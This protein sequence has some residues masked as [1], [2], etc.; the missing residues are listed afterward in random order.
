MKNLFFKGKD[1]CLGLVAIIMIALS[2]LVYLNTSMNI[3]LSPLFFSTVL[4][5]VSWSLIVLLSFSIKE[6]LK[7]KRTM[8]LISEMEEKLV[9]LE[10][11]K[12]S[13]SSLSEVLYYSLKRA[14][15]GDFEHRTLT[16]GFSEEERKVLLTFNAFMDHLE[17]FLR[18]TSA[19]IS[20]ASEGK[21][22]KRVNKKG[23][24]S[25]YYSVID[26]INHSVDKMKD[27]YYLSFENEYKVSLL[28]ENK[29]DEEIQ[30]VQETLSSNFND[31]KEMLD[32]I[33]L[34]VTSA[35]KSKETLVETSESTQELVLLVRDNKD[36]SEGLITNAD[37]MSEIVSIIKDISEQTNLL[38]LNAAIEAARAG[39]HGRGFA[40]V[41]DEVRKLAEKT[42]T[43]MYEIEDKISL[44][45]SETER[46]EENSEKM[47][48]TSNTTEET[49]SLL[50]STLETLIVEMSSVNSS[51]SMIENKTFV[52]LSMLDHI[53]YKNAVFRALNLKESTSLPNSTNCRFG[54]WYN[55]K[56]K[57]IFGRESIFQDI[58][59]YH[60]DVHK[61][62][63]YLTSE[64][65]LSNSSDKEEVLK[66]AK[67]MEENGEKLFEKL[68]Q[69]TTLS[70]RKE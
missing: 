56:G 13:L 40:V 59:K 23:L 61:L 11:K 49:L 27:S 29:V 36:L 4:G 15:N 22:Y 69:L 46:I 17:T 6:S 48:K 45:K 5:L 60:E 68:F 8:K 70:S 67:K 20:L 35:E 26:L 54:K 9:S 14:L 33:S 51:T 25:G 34:T 66:K 52:S 7:H 3:G 55:G 28:K 24:S 39:E 30:I 47:F 53:V 44:L 41:A 63:S 38:A 57:E 50:S 65:A 2:I 58:K 12:N 16:K 43:S 18:E 64:E 21:F 32:M 1:V 31:L 10:S 62:G 37:E 19:S 42:K